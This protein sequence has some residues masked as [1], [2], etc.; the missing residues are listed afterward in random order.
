MS[1]VTT[2]TKSIAVLARTWGNGHGCRSEYGL[3]A[4]KGFGRARGL[5]SEA[6][7]ESQEKGPGGP[8]PP[9]Q[10]L[11]GPEHSSSGFHETQ[12]KGSGRAVRLHSEAFLETQEKGLGGAEH[13]AWRLS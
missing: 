13:S 9:S 8:E 2:S 10:R 4:S 12:V 5:L 11:G 3:Y 1:S 6:F 7:L